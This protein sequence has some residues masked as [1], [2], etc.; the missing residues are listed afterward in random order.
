M[1][2]FQK[3]AKKVEIPLQINVRGSMFGFFFNENEVKNFDDALKSDSKMFAKFH[4]GML[5]RGFYFG[6]SQYETNFIST[7]IS[8]KI[9]D[10]T[11]K[12]AIEVFKEIA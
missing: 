12:A 8:S 10:K 5:E 2:S 1:N 3:E 6:C 4:Q 9:I 11:I 7:K